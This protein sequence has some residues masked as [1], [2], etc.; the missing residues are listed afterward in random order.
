[1]EK[2]DH[3][4]SERPS[5]QETRQKREG[6]VLLEE[7]PAPISFPFSELQNSLDSNISLW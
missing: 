1:M 6:T 7:S 5:V 4:K 3:V 2:R